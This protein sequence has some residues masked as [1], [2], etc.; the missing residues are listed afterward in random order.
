MAA[1]SDL[2]IKLEALG[3]S[4]ALSEQELRQGLRAIL[5]ENHPDKT[6]GYF[7]SA[8]Q[9]RVYQMANDALETIDASKTPKNSLQE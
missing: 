2:E 6:G 3:I 5:A 9:E 1:A 7:R 4:A 8:K